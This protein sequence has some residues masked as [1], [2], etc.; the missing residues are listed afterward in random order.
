MIRSMRNRIQD[1][2]WT[3][4][5]SFKVLAFVAAVVLWGVMLGRKD[6]TLSREFETQILVPPHMHVANDLPNRIYVEVAGPRIALK[7]FTSNK[8]IYTLDLEGLPEG[9]HLVRLS[10][11]GMNLPIGVK[12]LSIRP[13]E[14]KVNIE[15]LKQ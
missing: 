5:M 3:D 6:I 8:S 10:K 15:P 2:K 4:N 1:K 7:R 13:K 9:S 11:E 14:V 12:I